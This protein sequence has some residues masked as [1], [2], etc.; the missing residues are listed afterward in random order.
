MMK[1][2][3]FKAH[4]RIT[5]QEPMSQVLSNRDLI[6]DVSLLSNV[7]EDFDTPNASRKSKKSKKVMKFFR[8]RPDCRKESS[9][10]ADILNTICK[11]DRLKSFMAPQYRDSSMKSKFASLETMHK[12]DS[13]IKAKS[14]TRGFK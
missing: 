12:I 4:K 13:I 1:N 11:L 6:E 8:N 14:Q 2:I 9:K 5:N 10:Q 3:K 7:N